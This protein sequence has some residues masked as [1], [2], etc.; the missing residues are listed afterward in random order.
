MDT[1]HLTY[2]IAIVDHGGFGRAAT[3]LH[4]SQP[5]L[6][7][8]IKQFERSLGVQ[9]FHRV[10][11]GVALSEPGRQ[12]VKPAR[13]V[14]RGLDSARDAVTSTRDL[15]H[16]TV[17]LIATPSP[18]IEPLTTLTARFRR[19]HSGMDVAVAAA[20]TPDEA[21]EAVRSGAAELGLLG[22]AGTPTTADLALLP[23]EKQSLIL[24]SPP[25]TEGPGTVRSEDL[26]GLDVV[27]SPRGSLM[28]QLVDQVLA[29]GTRI[30][31]VAEVTHRTSLLPL[32]LADV[33]HSVMPESWRDLA[34]AAGCR[35]R[36]LEPAVHLD[37][38][39]VYH[40]RD[41][42]PGAHAF[43]SIAEEH[44]TPT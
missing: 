42:T 39:L 36:R 22:S 2:F 9:L 16:G 1:R 20:F 12:L 5:S 10:G 32:V 44:A 13:Q 4:V 6:S 38:S 25:G 11:R 33:G 21:V 15:D 31:V 17:D 3:A 7:Q 41:L 14:L 35:V 40:L 27:T 18:A 43:L 23:L 19:R 29:T 30:R 28:R 26:D 24:I 37:V 34:L 8:A